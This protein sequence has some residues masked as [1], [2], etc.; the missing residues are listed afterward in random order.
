MNGLKSLLS[1]LFGISSI[2]A[3]SINTELVIVGGGIIGGLEA[4]YAFKDAQLHNYPLRI[5]IY[6]QNQFIADSTA[7]RIVPSLT[8]DE[9]LAVIPRGTALIK[10]S[11]ILFSEPGGIRVDD[12]MGIHG[13]DATLAFQQQ[14]QIYSLDELGHAARTQHLLELGKM[15]MNLWHELYENGDN[16]L[17]EMLRLSNYN[18]CRNL[19]DNNRE[20]HKGYRIDL[21]YNIPNAQERA[22]NMKRDYEAIGYNQCTILTPA[23]VIALDPYLSDFCHNHATLNAQGV[24]EWNTDTVALWRPGGCLDV[25]VFLPLLYNYLQKHMGTYIAADGTVTNS[26]QIKL[27]HRV[28]KVHYATSN[29]QEMIIT[30][31]EFENGT[32]THSSSTQTLQS[33]ILCPGEAVGTLKAFGL[34]EPSYAGFAG[35]ALKLTIDIPKDKRE[36]AES[37][38]HCMEVHQEGVCLAWQARFRDNKIFIGVG[39]TKA[40]YSDQK[41]HKDQAFAK[42]RNL[43]QLNMINNVLPEFISWAFKR[44]THGVTLTEAD[45]A[46][47][48]DAGI[49]TR[50]AGRRAVAYD[51]FP[52]VGWVY[53]DGCR[54]VNARC[55]TH[56]GSGGV[57]FAPAAITISR[58]A[59][60]VDNADTFTKAILSYSRSNRTADQSA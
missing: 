27:G 2:G 28:T 17:R 18:P 52:S 26:F 6:E 32:T 22:L 4:Y 15:S 21:I 55:T 44:D 41:P 19:S 56:L 8:P 36:Y 43:L 51:G 20:L 37:F 25:S 16:E 46:Y 30:G 1:L 47:L 3:H 60:D 29:D 59:N 9:I 5:T 11:A 38:N 14:A 23:Q 39:G 54:V 13:S 49:A 34:H 57:S 35:A 31:L 50:W 7:A 40:F 58:T 12:V 33:Y 10:N 24:Q 42:N 48:E 53:K 45:L